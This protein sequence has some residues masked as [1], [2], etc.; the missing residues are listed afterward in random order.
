[1]NGIICYTNFGS[2][3]TVN[4]TYDVYANDNSKLT[5]SVFPDCVRTKN[6]KSDLAIK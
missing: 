1:M 3:R 2:V 5:Q 6:E 4:F